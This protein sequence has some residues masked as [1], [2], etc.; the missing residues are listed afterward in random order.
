M[1]SVQGPP[2]QFESAPTPK[3]NEQASRKLWLA[4]A[5]GFA[6]FLALS[7]GYSLTRSPWWDEGVFADVA[8]NFRNTGH[9]GSIVLAPHG[10]LNWPGVH[11]FTYWQ[12]PLYLITEGLWLRVMPLSI[13]SA[14]LLS[15]VWGCVYLVGWLLFVRALTRNT[16]LS[17]LVTAVVATDYALLST[18][19]DAR[20]D[21]MCAALG[22]MGLA[23]YVVLRGPK[24]RLAIISAGFFGAASLFCH[25]MGA[26]I[27]LAIVA[28]ILTLD[29]RRIPWSAVP[30]AA[31]FYVFGFAL[32]FWYAMQNPALYHAQS[33]AAASYRV[34]SV[35]RAV[36]DVLRDF[37]LR[38]WGYYFT[39]LHGTARLKVFCLLFGV[40]GFIAVALRRRLRS[41]V[42]GRTLLVLA[43]VSYVGVAL[44]DN[45]DFPMY[46]IYLMPVLVTCGAFWTYEEWRAAS[47]LRLISGA[48]LAAAVLASVGGFV[49]KIRDN[50]IGRQY[51]AAVRM[52]RANLPP[53]GTVFGGAELGF[54]LGFGPHLVDD[55]YLGYWSRCPLPAIYAMDPNYV[56]MPAEHAAWNQ[57]RK[58]LAE[59]YR[60]IFQDRDYRI[61]L[62][63]DLPFRH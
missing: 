28:V 31:L 36:R 22:Q 10:Y 26:V 41:S 24:P 5:V 53:D 17:L 20:M 21:M 49:V 54:A 2:K 58:D 59:H 7:I 25:P 32:C 38:Y 60:L 39:F 14:R 33:S 11:R 8:I 47:L 40:A 1:S 55:R 15:V 3:Q 57:S 48:L 19:S 44:I 35:V 18:A 51:E 29:W 50:D 45:Q 42:F 27:N 13:Q 23:S 46:F 16:N 9:L 63:D 56:A 61:Y 4:A 34:T 37:R 30:L 6:A 52:I 43:I 62:R 12:L